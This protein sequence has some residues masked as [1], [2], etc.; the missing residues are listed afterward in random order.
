MKE[1]RRFHTFF[2]RKG[3]FKDVSSKERILLIDGQQG[4]KK[5]IIIEMNDPA[6][7]LWRCLP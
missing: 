4:S 7:Y 2:R 3:A 6:M 5:I 1:M